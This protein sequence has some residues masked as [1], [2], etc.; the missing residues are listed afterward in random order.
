[1]SEAEPRPAFAPGSHSITAYGQ[2]AFAF[3]GMSHAGSILATPKGVRPIDATSVDDLDPAALAPLLTEIRGE[4]RLDRVSHRRDGREVGADPESVARRPRSGRPALRSDGD[5]RGA[6]G[7]QCHAVGRP[8][9]RGGADRR[10]VTARPPPGA[11]PLADAHAHCAGLARAHARDQWLGALYASAEARGAL[12]ALA[13]FDYEIRHALKRARDP[14]LTAIRLAWWREAI[15]GERQAEAAGN[16]VALALCAAI[17]AY[18]LPQPWLEAMLDARLQEIAPQD[19][20]NHVA[21]RAF[22]DESEGARLRLASRIAAGG[23]DLDPADA[24]AP[25][26]M[27]LA[28]TRLLKELPFKAGSAPTLI[29]TDVADRHGVSD[30]GFRRSA[31]ESRRYRRLRRTAGL[32]ARRARRGGASAEELR[33]CNPAGLHSACALAARPRPARPQCG[34]PV[35]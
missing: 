24:H 2:G 9:R 21:F 25:A 5:R 13:S 6:S 10:A 15:S 32:G 17:D 8:P 22:A 31:R 4:P 12:F 28:L 3:A 30:G 16:P 14:N 26:G 18:A 19:D 34:P 20:F 35:R 1:M 27:A 7:L 11:D 29:P 23:Q 33:P